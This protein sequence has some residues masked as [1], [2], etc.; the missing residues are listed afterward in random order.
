[1]TAIPH[2]WP[3]CTSYALE[4]KKLSWIVGAL[5]VVI[6]LVIAAP[7]LYKAARGG[8]DAPAPAVSTDGAV[9]AAGPLDGVWVVVPGTEPNTTTAGYT[10]DEVLRGEPVTVVGTTDRV[11]GEA[12]ISGTTLESAR[13]EARVEG[14]S[15]DSSQRDNRA[16]SA[17]ILDASA[18]PVAILAV[19]G[20]VDLTA[21][22]ED[23]ASAV[24]PMQVDLTIKGSTVRRVVDVTVLRSG[25]E[26]IASDSVPVTWTEVD[27]RAPNLGFVTVD[28]AGTIDFLVS[29]ARR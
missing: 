25:E 11:T 14:I 7:F 3:G 21:V 27:V 26:L 28:P 9:A 2:S 8:D 24:V 4:K 15:T 22:P 1:M 13:F 12:T 23:G 16:R 17:E 19:A 20:P 10:V 5:V 29:L 18:H 6:A